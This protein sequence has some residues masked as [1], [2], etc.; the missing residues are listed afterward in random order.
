MCPQ[1]LIGKCNKCVGHYFVTQ[2]V[3]SPGGGTDKD[4]NWSG[5]RSSRTCATEY[6]CSHSYC[7]PGVTRTVRLT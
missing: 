1:C 2:V 4:G 7:H 3:Q 5:E 6:A